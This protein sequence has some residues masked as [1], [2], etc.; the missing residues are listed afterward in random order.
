MNGEGQYR[1]RTDFG[2]I[3][4]ENA[5][6]LFFSIFSRDVPDRVLLNKKGRQIRRPNLRSEGNALLTITLAGIVPG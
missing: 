2:E 5:V 1:F 4:Q 6:K 3:I